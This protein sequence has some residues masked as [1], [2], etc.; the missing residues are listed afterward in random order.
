MIEIIKP[1][2]R[3]QVAGMIII[4]SLLLLGVT[5]LGVH[6]LDVKV[7]NV[8]LVDQGLYTII[9]DKG[10]TNIV[11]D[12]VLRIERTYTKAAITG[13]PVELDKIYTKKGFIYVS[14]LDPFAKTAHQLINS[15]DYYGQQIWSKANYTEYKTVQPYNY[16]IGTPANKIGILFF[17]L[18]LQYIVLSVGGIT[19]LTLIFPVTLKSDYLVQPQ[20]IM[21]TETDYSPHEEQFGAVAK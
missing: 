9:T 13:V 10:T 14:S 18:S 8:E 21:Q 19:L 15:V 17:L 5:I 7:Q 16:A 20:P 1:R 2:G 4:I 6:I 12:D 3:E 11:P